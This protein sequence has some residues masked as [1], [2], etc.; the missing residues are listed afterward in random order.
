M[1]LLNQTYNVRVYYASCD[2]SDI[3]TTTEWSYSW[4]EA[5]KYGYAI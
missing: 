3:L 2:M 4:G 5:K 1:L